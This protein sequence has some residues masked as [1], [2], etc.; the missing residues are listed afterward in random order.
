MN[1]DL[2]QCVGLGRGWG[3]LGRLPQRDPPW[4]TGRPN[5][6]GW[7]F[8]TRTV[9]H[10][11]LHPPADSAQGRQ[12][13][14]SLQTPSVAQLPAET[15]GLAHPRQNRTAICQAARA[16]T[17]PSTPSGPR[18]LSLL[19]SITW[20]EGRGPQTCRATCPTSPAEQPGSQVGLIQR[21]SATLQWCP[22]TQ[23][24]PSPQDSIFYCLQ[25]PR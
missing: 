9:Q 5:P 13:L 21:P 12:P 6:L 1:A 25:A 3:T 10:R 7:F 11:A 22:G 8:A 24:P 2:G 14:P 19:L 23:G 15:L 18:G 4:W 17:T 16:P 20:R